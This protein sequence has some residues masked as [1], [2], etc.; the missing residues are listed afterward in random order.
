MVGFHH[1][2]GS[3]VEFIYPPVHED[4]EGNLTGEFLRQIPLMAL[5]DG[6]HI[7]EGGYV[8]FIL[9]DEKNTYHC[10]SCYRQI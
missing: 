10:V 9:K 5:P 7:T 6:S 8:N 1:K 2:V 3:Q 4:K